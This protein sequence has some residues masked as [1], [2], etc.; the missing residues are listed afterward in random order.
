MTYTETCVKAVKDYCTRESK[1]VVAK[2][3]NS[4]FGKI[5]KPDKRMMFASLA[6]F[7]T[8]PDPETLRKKIEAKNPK[9][10]DALKLFTNGEV[11]SIYFISNVLSLSYSEV[12]DI[13]LF[14][15]IS[16]DTWYY[17]DDDVHLDKEFMPVFRPM[18]HKPA[19]L[20]VPVR[21]SIRQSY[22]SEGYPP[23]ETV[24]YLEKNI[25]DDASIFSKSDPMPSDVVD[26]SASCGQ[27]PVPAVCA[28]FGFRPMKAVA[29]LLLGQVG[30]TFPEKEFVHRN[31]VRNLI[32]SYFKPDENSGNQYLSL[33]SL[34]PY[35]KFPKADKYY[36]GKTYSLSVDSMQF[37]LS[38]FA[39]MEDGCWY[40]AYAMYDWFD[41]NSLPLT[42]QKLTSSICGGARSKYDYVDESTEHDNAQQMV[43]RA[44]YLAILTTFGILGIL[45]L[46]ESEDVPLPLKSGKKR[47][48]YS[49]CDGLKC[50]RMTPLGRYLLGLSEEMPKED[51]SAKGETELDS[52]L[53]VIS[54]TG[55][56]IEI[57]KLLAQTATELGSELYQV[58]PKSFLE[59]CKNA[60]SIKK[61]VE[62]FKKTLTTGT[63]PKNWQAF[64]DDL[65]TR[66]AA[67]IA[68]GSKLYDIPKEILASLSKDPRIQAIKGLY[69][70][71]PDHAA[72][73]TKETKAF[74]RILL[75]YG[76]KIG[77]QV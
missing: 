28:T 72:C 76:Y 16:I 18:F 61:Q 29:G 56:N 67:S 31:T 11:H 55:K 50:I 58:T 66:N 74:E 24:R 36:S 46:S 57:R 64:F 65:E 7:F 41:A 70:I 49:P 47:L 75:E 69:F 12:T 35:L 33:V 10:I 2:V 60:A 45:D 62:L 32:L 4:Y 21:D 71:P 44:L 26:L 53:L 1:E 22:P 8:V 59:S 6:D 39:A 54:Y 52:E 73:I 3:Y 25:L 27:I 5:D 48:P 63:L 9:A 37:L 15:F 43:F 68:H 20:P 13:L 23:M 51:P 19:P 40:D 77:E 42:S 38:Q 30:R 17:Y 34:L 14:G